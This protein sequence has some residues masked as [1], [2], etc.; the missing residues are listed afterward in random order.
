MKNN[1]HKFLLLQL[2][3]FFALWA[4]ISQAQQEINLTDIK[5]DT[6]KISELE[7]S[8]KTIHNRNPEL[9]IK[10]LDTLCSYYKQASKTNEYYIAKVKLGHCYN[11]LQRN[12]LAISVY[13]NCAKYFNQ[14]N[15]SLH[16][17]HVYTGIG[18]VY[19]I[20]KNY[21]KAKNY[22]ELGINICNENKIPHQKFTAI[23]I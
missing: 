12:Y 15:D 7:N 16:L 1:N 10:Q 2:I 3:F 18:N 8:V 22:Y 19:F 6:S 21:L 5:I 11:T 14:K 17:F 4:N 13:E 20:L 9:G 23:K